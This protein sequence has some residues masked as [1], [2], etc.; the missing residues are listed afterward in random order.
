MFEAVIPKSK[1]AFKAHKVFTEG[2]IV[3]VKAA[4]LSDTLNISVE[5]THALMPNKSN[6]LVEAMVYHLDLTS[7][8]S[9][10]TN[11]IL[12]PSY[13][14]ISKFIDER[15]IGAKLKEES[16]LGSPFIVTKTSKKYDHLDYTPLHELQ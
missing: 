8:W 3:Q 2:K 12:M 10:S 6:L 1:F 13:F 5:E 14:R 15:V 9:Q 16:V 7:Q 11:I 4:K